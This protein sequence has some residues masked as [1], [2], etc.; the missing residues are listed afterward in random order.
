MKFEDLKVGMEVLV[1]QYG[2]RS[3]LAN[4][5]VQA[6]TVLSTERWWPSLNGFDKKTVVV[7]PAT[8]RPLT[9]YGWPHE[10]GTM[11]PVLMRPGR[12]TEGGASLVK[13][14]RILGPAETWQPKIDAA[15]REQ[16]TARSERWTVAEQLTERCIE[17]EQQIT[18]AGIAA[19]VRSGGGVGVS[20]VLDDLATAERVV[21]LLTT[22]GGCSEALAAE[23]RSALAHYHTT[24]EMGEF[25]T[26][27]K[28][29]NDEE[30]RLRRALYELTGEHYEPSERQG[31]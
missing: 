11:V 30:A 19:S 4:A 23:A 7:D 31:Q 1:L 29:Y 16:G 20:I 27:Q 9:V 8:G 12:F 18:S 15:R 26:A 10:Q 22:A 3:D 25:L 13:L 28:R 5:S 17:L 2:K 14:R 6:A 21:N 24:G